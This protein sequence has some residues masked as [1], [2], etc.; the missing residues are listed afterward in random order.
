[1]K[2]IFVHAGEYTVHIGSGLLAR[3]GAM[4][5]AKKKPCRVFIVSDDTVWPMYGEKLA[6][7]LEASGFETGHCVVSHG[8]ENKTMTTLASILEAMA[9]GGVTRS[10]MVAALGG[11]VVGDMAGFAAAV[12]MRGIPF[13]QIPTTLLSAVD[14]SVGGKTAVDLSCG[15]NLA[16]AFHQPDM[17]LCDTDILRALPEPL[18][19][20]GAAEMIKCGVLGDADL[21]ESMKSGAWR[22]DLE[23]SVAACVQM[24][25]KLVDEDEKDN[26]ARQLLNLG[27]T[28]GHA[29]EACARFSISHGQGVAMGLVMAF[30]A[31]GLEDGEILQAVENCGL[32]GKCPYD[33]DVLSQAAL[34]DKKRRGGKITLVLPEKIGQCELRTV[35]VEEIPDYFRRGLGETV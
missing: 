21:F 33:A 34:R 17:V 30:R 7:S 22:Q 24:K 16:V 29:A 25:A 10:D 19:R 2:E 15:K 13:I 5:A 35:P 23:S 14:A 6:A 26:G 1:M 18:L 28:F 8:E 11:G 20:E 9:Q 27:H 31:A 12:Y 4:L 32:S 3:A